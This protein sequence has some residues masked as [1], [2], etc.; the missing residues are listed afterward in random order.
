M[1]VP[2]ESRM[3]KE[4][5]GQS[6]VICRADAHAYRAA[7]FVEPYP[8]GDNRDFVVITAWDPPISGFDRSANEHLD[9]MLHQK[10]I[11]LGADPVRTSG[12]SADLSH[13]EA[14]WAALVP[15]AEALNLAREFQQ[16]AIFWVSNGDLCLVWSD[17]EVEVLGPA[18][19]RFGRARALAGESDQ[20]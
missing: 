15:L 9:A 5:A 17:G 13:V 18:R 19:P 2:S 10:L 7:V 8:F 16:A 20:S 1:Q 4:H 14:G 3:S 11:E 6:G 12:A